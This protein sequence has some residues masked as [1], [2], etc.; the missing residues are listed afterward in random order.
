LLGEARSEKIPVGP[1]RWIAAM[2]ALSGVAI[3]L[4][5]ALANTNV[6]LPGEIFGLASSLLW[7]NYG[8]QSRK[9]S[10]NLNG[11]EVTAHTMWRAG[12]WLLPIAFWELGRHGLPVT[13]KLIGVQGYCIIA[14]GVI[15]F[16]LWNRALGQWPA[17]RVLLFNN[18]IPVS[19]MIWAYF[20]LGE[21]VT[22]TFL[23]ALLLIGIGVGLGQ[24]K[25]QI[26]NSNI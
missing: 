1:V 23:L 3:L 19:T 18:L 7:T 26:P 4:W 24:A 13:G 22:P 2:L 9:L 16:G 20:C 11:A 17:S 6:S 10:K 8:R 14:G 5:P 15:A 25:L 21:P 12:L